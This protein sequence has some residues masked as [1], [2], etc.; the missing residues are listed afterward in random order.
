MPT[1]GG[2]YE[3]GK[4]FALGGGFA[5][6]TQGQSLQTELT[7]SQA[8]GIVQVDDSGLYAESLSLNLPAEAKVEVRA[9]NEHRP[10]LVLSGDW[11]I[12]LAPGSELTLNGLLIAGGATAC[13]GSGCRRD[14][15]SA[16]SPL[17]VGPGAESDGRG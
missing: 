15:T 2:T 3:R 13:R 9:A 6:V 12:T 10:T 16:A 4:T 7:A 5:S 11:T 1:S 14:A 17:H 8:G